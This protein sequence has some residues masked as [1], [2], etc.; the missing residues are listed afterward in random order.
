MSLDKYELM[1]MPLEQI[2]E[3]PH[4]LMGVGLVP[5]SNM[6]TT[7]GQAPHNGS[8]SVLH[9]GVDPCQGPLSPFL[10]TT[11]TNYK[12]HSPTVSTPLA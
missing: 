4:K 5:T 2:D 10:Y 3:L 9:P 12:E 7:S 8:S 6:L 1:D 11:T